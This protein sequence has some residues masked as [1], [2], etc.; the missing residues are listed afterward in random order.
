MRNCAEKKQQNKKACTFCAS[1]TTSKTWTAHV[2]GLLIWVEKD[3]SCINEECQSPGEECFMRNHTFEN[4]IKSLKG[5]NPSRNNAGKEFSL[6]LGMSP[7]R[8]PLICFVRWPNQWS[9]QTVLRDI[10]QYV[11]RQT[12][13]GNTLIHEFSVPRWGSFEKEHY[14]NAVFPKA[15]KVLH[16]LDPEKFS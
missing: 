15:K 2:T 14:R 12:R 11:Q 5:L 13:P 1:S 7:L 4:D 9:D 10:I 8:I 16:A 3:W 6:P